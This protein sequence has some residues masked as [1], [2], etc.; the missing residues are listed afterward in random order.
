MAGVETL[1]DFNLFSEIYDEARE[2][3]ERARRL[4]AHRATLPKGY[5]G[6]IASVSPVLSSYFLRADVGL[7]FC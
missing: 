5:V 7:C 4:A 6:K 3:R 1:E 2:A